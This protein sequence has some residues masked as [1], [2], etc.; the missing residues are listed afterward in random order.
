MGQAV[1]GQ[2][3]HLPAS[4]AETE[5]DWRYTLRPSSPSWHVRVQENDRL[6]EWEEKRKAAETGRK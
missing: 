1:R 6:E 5:N 4:S 3:D 2:S